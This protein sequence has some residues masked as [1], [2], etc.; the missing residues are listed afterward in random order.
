LLPYNQQEN[1]WTM[2]KPEDVDPVTIAAFTTQGC[3]S[4]PLLDLVSQC[5][6]L[7]SFLQVERPGIN[8]AIT[9]LARFPGA[10]TERAWAHFHIAIIQKLKQRARTHGQWH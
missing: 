5:L 2:V 7:P 10:S 9:A 4:I 3:E 6:G 8:R 1:I